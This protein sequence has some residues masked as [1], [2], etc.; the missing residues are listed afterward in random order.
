MRTPRYS[1]FLLSGFGF[2][3]EIRSIC[4][5]LMTSPRDNLSMEGRVRLGQ[6]LLVSDR[7]LLKYTY[8]DCEGSPC[9]STII[10][11]AALA[12]SH[13]ALRAMN[14]SSRVLKAMVTRMK[15]L[16][17]SALTLQYDFFYGNLASMVWVLLVGVMAAGEGNPNASWFMS[18]LQRSCKQDDR[19]V[20]EDIENMAKAPNHISPQPFLWLLDESRLQFSSVSADI[21]P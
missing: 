18:C 6:R 12:Y 9:I 2:L 3:D 14:R 21:L 7:H 5:D 15:Y 11:T 1:Y 4:T 19:I 20:W 8:T 17:T 10:S 13:T 16:L